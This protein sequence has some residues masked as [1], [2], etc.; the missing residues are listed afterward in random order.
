MLG[1]AQVTYPRLFSA[2]AIKG[3]QNALAVFQEEMVAHNRIVDRPDLL[4]TF[5]EI[6]DLTGLPFLEALEQRYAES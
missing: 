2:A 1:V 6:N 4:V 5:D 3:M